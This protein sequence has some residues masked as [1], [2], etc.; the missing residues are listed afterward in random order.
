VFLFDEFDVLDAP[1]EEQLPLTAAA[2]AFFPYLRHLMESEPRLAFIFVVGRKAEDLS[3]AVK[4]TFKASRYQRVSVLDD[5]GARQLVG[6]A[7]RNGSLHFIPSAVDR[8]LALTARHPYFTQ[9]M[10]QLLFDLAYAA[11]PPDAPTMDTP[12]IEAIVPKAL[13]AGRAR[14]R[15]D[16]GWPPAGRAGHLL[17]HCRCNRGE[18]S[19]HR[20][21]TDGYL[22]APR[23][24]H[25]DSGA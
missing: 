7:E 25:P 5:E 15:V 13:E 6:L 2:R 12:D 22:A 3:I 1:A 24:P 18:A 4:A 9:L 21:R 17:G 16:L 14:L 20:G 11:S 10:C 8:L 23:H 19:H